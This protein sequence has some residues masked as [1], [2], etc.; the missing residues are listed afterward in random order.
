MMSVRQVIEIPLEVVD[1]V[2]LS[3]ISSEAKAQKLFYNIMVRRDIKISFLSFLLR[4]VY[5]VNRLCF[6]V[7]CVHTS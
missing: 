1:K 7:I 6:V 2:T 3:L 4:K 5:E